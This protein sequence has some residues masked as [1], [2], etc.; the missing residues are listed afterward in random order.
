MMNADT[1]L[2]LFAT[3]HLKIK[4]YLPFFAS[5]IKSVPKK[6][7]LRGL[8]YQLTHPQGKLIRVEFRGS[9]RD[10]AVDIR[11]HSPTYGHYALSKLTDKNKIMLYIP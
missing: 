9:I 3:R 2:N 11:K 1:V 8:H 6:N 7:V 5:L 10:V 4:D